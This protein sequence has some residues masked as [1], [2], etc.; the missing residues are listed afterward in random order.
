MNSI[1]KSVFFVS[2]IAFALLIIFANSANAVSCTYHAYKLCYGN[3]IY[4][5]DSCDN[6]QDLYQTCIGTNQTCKYGQCVYQ[7]PANPYVAY[8]KKACYGNNIYWY[9]SLG[10]VS[11]FYKSCLDSNTCTVDTCSAG[12]CSNQLKCD[13]TTCAALSDDYIKYCVPENCGNNV[14]DSDLGETAENCPNDCETDLSVSF[15][16]SY[17]V[18]STEWQ[19][20]TQVGQNSQIYF[21]VVVTNNGTNKVE[22]IIVSADIPSEIVSLGNVKIDGSAISRDIVSGV[23]IGALEA[24]NVKTLTFEG[25]TQAF[26]TQRTKQAVISVRVSEQT[27]TDFVD[28]TF[29]PSQTVGAFVSGAA[30]N[31]IWEFIKRWYLWILIGVVLIFLF[32]VV[33]RRLSAN[34]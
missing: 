31:N 29:N 34:V 11:A 2:A 10:S 8:Y 28:I 1:T 18:S 22:D 4:W 32:I 14:C 12:A 19:E 26:S 27:Q 5:Y 15:F 3:S 13:G 7:A 33:F 20:S 24:S 17:D 16:G 6:R 9:D 30:T 25:K 23:N 21:M